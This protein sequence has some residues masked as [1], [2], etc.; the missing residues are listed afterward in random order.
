MGVKGRIAENIIKKSM[1]D[2]LSLQESILFAKYQFT[3]S[4]FAGIIC[5]PAVYKLIRK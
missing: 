5:L 4:L 3:E 1:R 2:Y